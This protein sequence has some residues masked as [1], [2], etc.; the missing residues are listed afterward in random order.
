MPPVRHLSASYACDGRRRRAVRA[1]TLTEIMVAM[2]ILGLASVMT[3]GVFVATLKRADHSELALKGTAE[4]RNASD[5]ISQAVRSA[6]QYPTIPSV[7]SPALPGLK[8]LVP[9]KDVAYVAVQDITW[10][11]SANTIKGSKGNQRVLKLSDLTIPSVATSVW[12]SA[13]RPSGTVSSATF[14]TYFIGNAAVPTDTDLN[15][16]FTVGDTITIPAT[17]FGVRTQ[18]VINSISSNAGTKTITLT[19]AIG[20]DVPNGTKIVATSGRKMMFEV[21]NTNDSHK[22]ELRYYPD[23]SDLTHYSILARDIDP[24]PLSDPAKSSSARTT[25]FAIAASPGNY[26]TINLQKLPAA[27]TTG[28]TLQGIRTTAFTRTD[29]TL[30]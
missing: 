2:T 4:L 7:T 1:F 29:P 20:V 25:P 15:D 3:M 11:D 28:R 16:Y 10:I 18:G 8:L 19:N 5:T 17:S 14:S 6:S 30:Q 23:S 21:V 22:G 12:S 9:P 24:Q 13:S 26:V 27:T